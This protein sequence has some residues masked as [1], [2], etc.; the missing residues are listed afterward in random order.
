MA[1]TSSIP[2]P[3]M[4]TIRTQQEQK[5]YYRFNTIGIVM[6]ALLFGCSVLLII[7]LVCTIPYL[8]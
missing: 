1:D 5:M 3:I 8:K 7:A 6:L 2:A 4:G